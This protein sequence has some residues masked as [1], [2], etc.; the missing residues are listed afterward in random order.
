MCVEREN[1]QKKH[2]SFFYYTFFWIP[3]NILHDIF[4][5]FNLRSWQVVQWEIAGFEVLQTSLSVTD[6]AA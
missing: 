2:Q 4:E 5:L 3:R 1:I 6:F